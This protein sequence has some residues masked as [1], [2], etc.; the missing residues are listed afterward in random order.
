MK[1]QVVWEI[2]YHPVDDL[3]IQIK[4][5]DQPVHFAV[6][7]RLPEEVSLGGAAFPGSGDEDIS[8]WLKG[9]EDANE[10]PGGRKVEPA[11]PALIRVN[12]DRVAAV[13]KTVFPDSKIVVSELTAAEGLWESLAQQMVG[14]EIQA[15]PI[16]EDLLR[17]AGVSAED[18][19][20][21][22]EKMEKFGDAFLSDYYVQWL[23]NEIPM[24]L[25]HFCL[26]ICGRT[27]GIKWKK[28]ATSC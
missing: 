17:Q 12:N 1:T 9:L 18:P 8:Q 21:T 28:G 14:V 13:A 27:S 4:D 26:Y 22:E 10:I 11:K 2:A 19:V 25:P 6:V 24:I 23:D 3:G 16:S 20:L 5:V 15:K 7:V